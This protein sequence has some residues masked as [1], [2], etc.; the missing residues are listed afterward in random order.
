M[1][2]IQIPAYVDPAVLVPGAQVVAIFDGKETVFVVD[3]VE[4]ALIA[5]A[6]DGTSV[7]LLAH[8]TVPARGA[9]PGSRA[10]LRAVGSDCDCPSPHCCRESHFYCEGCQC[11]REPRADEPLSCPDHPLETP[12]A[13]HAF[14]GH[15]LDGCRVCGQGPAVHPR[16]RP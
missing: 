9:V 16:L 1:N 5:T 3:H 8:T 12:G 6:P 7:V 11:D 4:P 14:V 2:T 13:A 10:S 15:R